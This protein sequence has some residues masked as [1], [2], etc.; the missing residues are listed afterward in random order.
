MFVCVCVNCY[1]LSGVSLNGR[2][3]LLIAL[4]QAK[5]LAS[6]AQM[7]ITGKY[8]SKSS[9]QS[10]MQVPFPVIIFIVMTKVCS[11][12]FSPTLLEVLLFLSLRQ[13]YGFRIGSTGGVTIKSSGQSIFFMAMTQTWSLPPHFIIFIRDYLDPILSI[14]I[15][16]IILISTWPLLRQYLQ[17]LSEAHLNIRL[18]SNFKQLTC[19]PFL[20]PPFFIWLLL[21]P[22]GALVVIMVY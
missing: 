15:V 21:A 19:G 8:F 4:I 22:S 10:P 20:S 2:L 9:S 16:M 11:S 3:P 6:G 7:N 13:S 18:P 17:F 14:V 5:R 1:F 12:T